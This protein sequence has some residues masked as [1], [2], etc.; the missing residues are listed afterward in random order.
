VRAG[1]GRRIRGRKNHSLQVKFVSSFSSTVL[2]IRNYYFWFGLDLDPTWRVISDPDPVW[3]VIPDPDTV[4]ACEIFAFK[5][6]IYFKRSFCAKIKLFMSKMLFLSLHLSFKRPN[7]QWWFRIRIRILPY[8]SGNFGYGSW[9]VKTEPD[10]QHC[11]PV[12]CRRCM[13][14]FTAIPLSPNLSCHFPLPI[15]CWALILTLSGHT[16]V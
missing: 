16:A 10:P 1:A 6:G 11:S 5:V 13:Y 7:P 2:R 8:L 12:L 3:R 15:R 14:N 4:L 9:K